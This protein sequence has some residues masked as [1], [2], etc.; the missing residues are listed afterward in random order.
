MLLAETIDGCDAI[1]GKAS[2]SDA[3]EHGFVTACRGIL[4]GQD[5]GPVGSGDPGK[6]HIKQS[7]AE[8][9][10]PNRGSCHRLAV[11]VYRLYGDHQ[12][13]VVVFSTRR[14]IGDGCNCDG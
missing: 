4:A 11:F 10:E 7:V 8:E 3:C 12:M 13:P 1:P 5:D 2:G 14:G 9:V 6:A